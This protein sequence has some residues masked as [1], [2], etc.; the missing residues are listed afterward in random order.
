M[1]HAAHPHFVSGDTT[2]TFTHTYTQGYFT[3]VSAL[4]RIVAAFLGRV[5]GA[6]LPRANLVL[7]GAGLDTLSFRLLEAAS[8]SA[9]SSLSV[10]SASAS[11]AGE[12]PRR[13][14]ETP[15]ASAAAAAGKA[16]LALSCFEVDLAPV[17]RYKAACLRACPELL[18]AVGGEEKGAAQEG[19]GLLMGPGD[20]AATATVVF[21]GQG[22]GYAL[23]AGDLG[24]TAGLEGERCR[25]ECLS[26]CFFVMT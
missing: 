18:G 14:E 19:E 16:G 12:G 9:A 13:D 2:H 17:A 5:Q 24:D 6:A 26:V 22:R 4:E 23:V 7:L 1:T 20:M 15:A 8:S 10:A 3:R 25:I 21:R 11:S